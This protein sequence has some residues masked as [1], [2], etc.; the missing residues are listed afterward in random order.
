MTTKKGIRL[1]EVTLMRCI[2]AIL[3]VFVHSFTC[4]NDSWREPA[5]FIDIPAYRWLTRITF[6][7]ALEGF[8]LISGYI[9]AYQRI[10]L[11]KYGSIIKKLKRLLLPSIIFSTAY[12][13]L[14]YQYEGFCDMLYDIINGCGHMWYLPMLFWCFVGASLLERIPIKDIFKLVILLGIY[15]LPRIW[16]PLQLSST[17]SYILYFHAGYI[18]F[19]YREFVKNN[20]RLWHLIL[21]WILFIFVFAIFRPVQDILIN[22]NQTSILNRI[23][24]ITCNRI[25]Q[26]VFSSVGVGVFYCTAVY[27][28]NKYKLRV[29]TVKL[30]SVCFGI[31]ILQQFILQFL[32]YKTS[33]PLIV[34]PYWLPWLGFTI[35]IVLSFLLSTIMIRTKC[36]KFLIG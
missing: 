8:V 31:Y 27:Y 1:D 30:S 28:I 11:N 22:S 12:F 34:G 10:I 18:L 19:K 24:L 9:F 36:G 35:T 23:I 20:I 5:G 15:L 13:V 32:Y 7:F 26:L 14:F 29:F 16:L 6:A 25:S 4:Y 21:G 3:I 33:F 2:L 17:M